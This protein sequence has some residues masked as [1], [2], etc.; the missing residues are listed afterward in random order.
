[1]LTTNCAHCGV[2]N[3]FAD[4]TCVSCGTD[5]T[6]DPTSGAFPFLDPTIPV[7]AVG[8]FGF[9]DMVGT[10]LKVFTANLWLITKFVFV[11]V[12]PFEIFKA[13]NPASMDENW[14]LTVETF[15]LGALCQLLIA[16]AL[17]YAL[18]KI[19]H[20]GEAPGIN[21]AYR[22]GL[23]KLGRLVVCALVAGL[24]QGLGYLFLIIPGIIIGLAFAVVY[25][26]AVLEKGSVSEVLGRSS[27]LTRGNRLSI[28]GAQLVLAA[29]TF[30][31]GL[32][33]GLVIGAIGLW[34]FNVLAAIVADV[35]E[36]TGTVLSLVIYL[37]LVQTPRSGYSIL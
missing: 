32:P 7:P 10:T 25:P 17:I 4:E 28:L 15:A 27:Q 20:T 12:T 13:L 21:E 8:P 23:T 35:V 3:Q 34:P 1:M 24:L 18:M 14:Q 26:I 6:L 2:L 16:P 5:L 29:L 33:L 11:V 22:W 31:I 19:M 30:A 36:Q 9:T 37:S